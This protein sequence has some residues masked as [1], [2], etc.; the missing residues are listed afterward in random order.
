MTIEQAVGHIRSHTA[1]GW[2]K[3]KPV[4]NELIGALCDALWN[5]GEHP[6]I[7]IILDHLPNLHERAI[8]PGFNAWRAARGLHHHYPRWANSNIGGPGVLARI[9]SPEIASAP[10]TFFD[11]HNDGRWQ[12]PHPKVVAYLAAIRN[13]S[14]RDVMALYALIKSGLGEQ[15]L[16]CRLSSYAV[17]LRKLMEEYGLASVHDIDPDDLLLRVCEKEAGSSLTENQRSSI[18]LGWNTLSNA[19][20][21]YGERLDDVHRQSL[22]QFFLKPLQKRYR[23]HRSRPSILVRDR[24][25]ERVKAK[26]EAVHRQFHKLRFMAKIRCNQAHRLYEAVRAAIHAVIDGKLPLP[27]HFNYDE[28]VATESARPIQQR[29]RMTLWDSTSL[30]DHAIEIG[31]T[32]GPGKM[33]CAR[34]KQVGRFAPDRRRFIVQYRGTEPVGDLCLKTPFWFLDLYDHQV[35]SARGTPE[36]DERRQA[37]FHQH[38][39]SS[40]MYWEHTPGL[41]KPLRRYISS[42]AT[43]LEREHGYQFL[44]Y[45]GIYATCLF[46]HLVVRMQTVTG[47]RIGEVQQIAQNA[48]CIKQLVNVGPKATT[49]WVLRMI[50][51]GRKERADYFIDAET[52][53]VLMEVL[54]LHREV[55]GLKKLPVVNHQSSKYAA[56]RYLLQWNDCALDQATLNTALRF[57]LHGAV[58]DSNGACVHLTTHVLRHG[59]AT[60]M[61]SLKV[62]IEVI[63]QI[64]HQRNLEVTRYYSKPTKQQVMEAAELLFVERID[65]AAEALRSP[66]E[67]GRM[68][69][70][71]EGQIGALT[72]VIGG[73]CVVSNMCPVKFACIGCSG[74]APDPDRRYQIEKKRNW[75]LQQIAWAGR[76]G[77]SAE[78]RQMKR[79]INDCDLLLEEMTLIERARMDSG[80]KLVLHEEKFSGKAEKCGAKSTMA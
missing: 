54:R 47:A 10:L 74:N 1:R 35:F 29:V 44:H 38:G 15:P 21:E 33:D 56:D 67:I 22:S 55:L 50:P 18:V 2:N 17:P 43:F 40:R 24:R 59:F 51:K 76:E 11:A 16:Y 19:F 12:A 71:A 63:A 75:A 41:V 8:S 73:T 37:F 34:K 66:E 13:Q 52:K 30:W 48:E 27:Y 53:D 61:A 7:Q 72:E 3:S 64:L 4:P 57:L 6:Q 62:P 20:Q 68:L 78:E 36:T 28:T 77:L 79:L 46:A 70:E 65:V 5:A 69:R 80:Q 58:L 49:R 26:T 32:V 45:E 14:L 25:H 60:E 39:Y 31:H 42:D 9:V 23:M